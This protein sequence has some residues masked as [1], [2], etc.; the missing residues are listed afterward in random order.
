MKATDERMTNIVKGFGENH[1]AIEHIQTQLFES[2]ESLE[3]TF[4]TMSAF[5]S[6]QIETAR[7]L[8]S[9][10]NELLQGIYDLVE[11][12]L[13]P[14]VIKPVTMVNTINDIQ[15]IL[16]KKFPGFHLVYKDPSLIYHNVDTFFARKGNSVYVSVTFPISPFAQPFSSSVYQNHHG[17]K[18]A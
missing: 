9:I 12:K 8:E 17:S 7:Q 14:N 13:S 1:V 2:F 3:K 16:D 6:K 5:T 10:F 11:G 18:M 4:S 15:N